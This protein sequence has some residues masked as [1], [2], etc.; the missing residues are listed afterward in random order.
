MGVCRGPPLYGKRRSSHQG[1]L[2]EQH[3][4]FNRSFCTASLVPTSGGVR[5]VQRRGG[6]LHTAR[7]TAD[8]MDSFWRCHQ[9][10]RALLLQA[11]V[12]VRELFLR[13][14]QPATNN[15]YNV[16]F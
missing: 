14:A 8:E 16:K 3:S 12:Q 2:E 9:E 6:R 4:E 7:L 1:L 5:K 11:Y 13:C 15:R 10:I